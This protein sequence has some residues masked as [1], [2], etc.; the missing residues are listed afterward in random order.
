[1][2]AYWHLYIIECANGHLYTG[3]TT[4]INRRFKEHQTGGKK[5]AKYLKGKGP[6]KLKYQ[7]SIG[8]HSQALKRE[9]A[10]KKLSRAQKLQ[11]IN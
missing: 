2:A 5:T 3:I 7:E 9:I 8:D 6:L 10:I 1:M 4:D 11:L